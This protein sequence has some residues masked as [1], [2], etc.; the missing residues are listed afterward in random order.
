MTTAASGRAPN[1]TADPADDDEDNDRRPDATAAGGWGA[2]ARGRRDHRRTGGRPFQRARE[3]APDDGVRLIFGHHAVEAALANPRRVVLAA[4]LT[5]NAARR[6]APVLARRTV[7]VTPV[8]PRELDRRLGPDTVHQGALLEVEDLDEPSLADLAEAA[9]HRPIVILDQVTDPHNVGAIL[10]SCSVFGAGGVVMTRRHAPPL[11]G[12]LAKAASGALETM[13]IA[14]VGNLAR[15]LADLQSAGVTV[16]GLDDQGSESIEA[17]VWPERPALVLGAEGK[18]LREL[19]AKTCDRLIRIT[20]EGPI[21]SLNVSNA[22]AVSLHM[23]AIA[24][25]R[26]G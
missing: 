5:D 21:D 23:A 2:P 12:V 1:R 3:E 6:L 8:S 11:A 9:Q 13:P 14:R 26:R 16:L 17:L 25:R 4:M 22:A 18:G 7:G 24:R 10:R 19:T 15:A 20:A